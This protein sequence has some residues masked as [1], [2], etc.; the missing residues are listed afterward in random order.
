[1]P[2]SLVDADSLLAVD[3]GTVTTRAAL[4][5]VVEGHYRFIASG[6][7]PTTAASPFRD[8]SEGV[9]QA[10]E[11][12]QI[13]TGCKFLDEGHR[14][15]MPT[16]EGTGVDTFAATLSAGPAIKTAVVGLLDDVSLE[17]TQRLARSIY[18]RVVETIGLNDARKP[19]EQI[20]SLVRLRPDL[21]LIAGGTDGGAARSVRRLIET[22]GLACYLLPVDKRPA[23]LFAG[24]QRLADEV[25]KSLQPLTSSLSI[26]PNLRPGID[27]EDLQPAQRALIE[28]YT[29]VRRSQMN[30]LD[31]LNT[32]AG[33]TLIPTA[34]AEGRII[35]FLSKV[36]DSSK[37][38]LG[39]DLGAS[40]V[41][42]AA[43]FGGELT[44]GVYPQLGL[45]ESLANLLRYT[46]L[47]DILK[48]IPTEIPAEAVRDYLYQK[49]IYPASLPATPEDL[50]IEQAVA[51]QSLYV[52]LN[53]AAK[54]FPRKARRAALGLRPYFEPILAAGSVITRAPTLGQG[55]LIL[56][57]AIQPVGITTVILDQ[58]NLLPALGAAASRNS[59][60]PIQ[61][62][63]SG[64]FLGLAT[65][66]A[67][68]AKVRLGTP[69]L[70]ARLIHPNGNESRIEVKQGALEAMPLP[71]GQ[72]GRL[73]LQPLHN[74]DLGFGP[75]RTR[76]DGIPITGTA[77][78]LVID[79]RGRP[80]RFP[81]DDVRRR[82]LIKK[83]LW[84]L[85]G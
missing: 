84:T 72:S 32:W 42:V 2:A 59:I 75:G 64:A 49:S 76:E 31:E 80:L 57:D 44:L 25:K 45:G 46:S 23:L 77:L 4:F 43:A 29:Q 1:M 55:L 83:W 5:D 30:G 14:L 73:Y 6:H 33:N 3:V 63:E 52:A 11:N 10:I 85:G 65:V 56:L 51:R 79:A 74:A 68:Y 35:R 41:T 7:A 71:A 22:V 26:S 66:V 15:I 13:V 53:S 28:L 40:A 61:V 34:S 70:G 67:P 17:S 62:L 82:E 24:N 36:Y 58:N 81:A 47:E 19:E 12:L 20:D 38:I 48:W 37:G 27:I 18:A 9:R 69:V 8:V 39:V 78:G 60:L 50:S 21:I 54:D 16:S